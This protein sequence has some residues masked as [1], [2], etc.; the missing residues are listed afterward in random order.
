MRSLNVV[1]ACVCL[2]A[3]PGCSRQEESRTSTANDHAMVV[4]PS[5]REKFRADVDEKLRDLDADIAKA[6]SKIRQAS[7]EGKEDAKAGA[8]KT[9]QELRRARYEVARA[10]D[11]VGNS[12]E[13]GWH[14][15]KARFTSAYDKAKAKV[16][17]ALH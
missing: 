6:E 7:A 15:A 8:D 10:A 9:V 17:D 14:D 11:E 13:A 12:T 2:A 16:K 1:A 4:T 3:S 5:E